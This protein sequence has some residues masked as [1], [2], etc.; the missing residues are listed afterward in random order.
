MKEFELKDVLMSDAR[1]SGIC[2]DG[3][4]EMR[5][6]DREALIEMY[7]RTLD[8]SLERD[9]PSIELLR[10]EFADIEDKGV[11]VDK[12]FNGEIFSDKQAYVFHH[13]KGVINVAMNYEKAII[14]MIYIANDCDI[15]VC[16]EQTNKPKI[17]T[18]VYIFGENEVFCENND[19]AEYRVYI[20]KQNNKKKG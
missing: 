15:V 5:G 17:K 16:C 3:Y 18:P 4:S 8:W 14:P 20:R 19:N 11:Y 12:E 7:L 10:R 1:D 6:Y 13:C 2:K 9:F